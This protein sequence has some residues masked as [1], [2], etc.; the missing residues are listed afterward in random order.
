KKNQTKEQERQNAL[1]NF[2]KGNQKVQNMDNER[3]GKKK[4]LNQAALAAYR[5]RVLEGRGTSNV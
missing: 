4:E 5:R 3:E 1:T 2:A